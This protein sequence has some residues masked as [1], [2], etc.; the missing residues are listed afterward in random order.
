[1]KEEVLSNY[2]KSKFDGGLLGLIGINLLCGFLNFITL[3]FALPWTA[4]IKR[5]WYISH[6]KY[7]GRAL[8]FDGK[9]SQLIGNYLLWLL[10]S[11]ITAGIFILFIPVKMKNWLAKHTHFADGKTIG[12]SKF[13]GGTLGFWGVSIL[14]TILNFITA[15]IALPFVIAF[16]EKWEKDHTVVDGYLLDFSGHGLDLFGHWL[17]WMLLS[18]ITFFIYAF[19]LPLKFENWKTKNTDIEK[20]EDEPVGKRAKKYS[21]EWFQYQYDNPKLKVEYKRSS[22]VFNLLML[23]VSL[24]AVGYC[25]HI[26]YLLIQHYTGYQ[27]VPSNI[28][29]ILAQ[30]F[31]DMFSG[32]FYIM[33]AINSLSLTITSFKNKFSIQS[34]KQRLL[35]VMTSTFILGNLAYN[36][37]VG[38]ILAAVYDIEIYRLLELLFL[39]FIVLFFIVFLLKNIF[40]IR[41]VKL[42]LLLLI[43]TSISIL[44]SLVPFVGFLFSGIFGPLGFLFWIFIVL[45]IITFASKNTFSNFLKRAGVEKVSKFKSINFA[46]LFVLICSILDSIYGVCLNIILGNFNFFP[47]IFYSLPF[48][49]LAGFMYFLISR[50]AP[51]YVKFYKPMVVT[52][53]IPSSNKDVDVASMRTPSVAPVISEAP[54]ISQVEEDINEEIKTEPNNDLFNVENVLAFLANEAPSKDVEIITDGIKEG[55]SRGWTNLGIYLHHKREEYEKAY[56]YYFKGYELGDYLG[57]VCLSGL[58][59]KGIGVPV[60]LDKAD[61][62]EEK[63]AEMGDTNSLYI[64][65]SR[66]SNG[67]RVPKD[68]KKALHYY[69]LGAEA[70]DFAANHLL[71]ACYLEGADLVDYTINVGKAEKYL[72]TALANYE[73]EEDQEKIYDILCRLYFTCMGETDSIEVLKRAVYFGAKAVILFNNEAAAHNLEIGRKQLGVTNAFIEQVFQMEKPSEPILAD[74]FYIENITPEHHAETEPIITDDIPSSTPTQQQNNSGASSSKRTQRDSGFRQGITDAEVNDFAGKVNVYLIILFLKLICFAVGLIVVVWTYNNIQNLGI[75]TPLFFLGG[76]LVAGLPVLSKSYGKAV[77]VDKKWSRF[78]K[79][80]DYKATIYSD[81]NI[82]V[83]ENRDWFFILFQTILNIVTYAIYFPFDFLIGIINVARYKRRIKIYWENK[84]Q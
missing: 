59:A 15:F 40:S 60:D 27:L 74:D 5:G 4:V 50:S 58:Y 47:L 54:A 19:W 48:I 79:E 17:L 26:V 42:R 71:G 44:G 22:R 51:L 80:A 39:T 53:T 75:L 37:I 66:Y 28:P 35:L 31:V 43:L 12:E 46:Y 2:E 34:A 45:I 6:T 23:A 83:R 25:G 81:G 14:A 8:S 73:D 9:G 41:S 33:V 3:S 69:S 56:R 52:N 61:E 78:F 10:L 7:N 82:R 24:I 62:W 30:L 68:L 84:N 1:M 64:V 57:A 32:L 76:I 55:T 20:P 29:G 77:G 67:N 38:I 49:A 65:A 21:Q 63:A 70:D 13:T 18:I 11:I 16:V 36:R 72:I